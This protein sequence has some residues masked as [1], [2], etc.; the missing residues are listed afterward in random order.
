MP[1]LSVRK[2]KEL[3]ALV[4]PERGKL[5]GGSCAPAAARRSIAKPIWVISLRVASRARSIQP[6]R[7]NLPPTRR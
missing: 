3:A 4:K 6:D 2:R 7:D 5:A 1:K